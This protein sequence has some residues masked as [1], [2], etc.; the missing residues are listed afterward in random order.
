MTCLTFSIRLWNSSLYFT[1]APR[2]LKSNNLVWLWIWWCTSWNSVVIWDEKSMQ[3]HIPNVAQLLHATV[4]HHVQARPAKN[5]TA[6]LTYSL[7]SVTPHTMQYYSRLNSQFASSL[8][9]P[10]NLAGLSSLSYAAIL[11]VITCFGAAY[12]VAVTAT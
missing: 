2:Y 3:V 10:S 4:R 5:I 8:D 1:T 9:S 6:T 7:T 11:P 12:A